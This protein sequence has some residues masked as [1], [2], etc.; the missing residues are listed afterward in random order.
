MNIALET[1][2][3]F[4]KPLAFSELDD[5]FALRS[6]PDVMKYIGVTK[7][8]EEVEDFIQC[9]LA[10]EPGVSY[11]KKYG[12]DFFSVFEKKTGQFIGQAGLFHVRFN[13]T[14]PDI[15]LAYRL[16]KAYW[17]HGYATELAK[18]LIHYGF[19]NLSLPKIIATVHPDNVPSKR[20]V[21]KAGMTYVGEIENKDF[22]D[23]PFCLYQ[24][25]PDSL[26]KA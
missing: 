21:E 8:K 23:V 9:G 10:V 22:K 14:C 18:A 3:L 16:H 24:I 7:T 25:F 4:L 5:L 19:K 13:M 11:Y 6:D 26:N 20:V 1:N 12:M 2:R 17:G 15:E